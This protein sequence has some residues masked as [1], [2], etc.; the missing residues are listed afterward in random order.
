MRTDGLDP[1]SDSRSLRS[2]T[3]TVPF[4]SVAADP[5]FVY[6]SVPFIM[7]DEGVSFFEEGD[8]EVTKSYSD[9]HLLDPP[10][11]AVSLLSVLVWTSFAVPK[12]VKKSAA[13]S[14]SPFILKKLALSDGKVKLTVLLV[15]FSSAKAAFCFQTKFSLVCLPKVE[16]RFRSFASLTLRVGNFDDTSVFVVLFGCNNFACEVSS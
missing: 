6:A 13:S 2:D 3:N 10:G 1:P 15:S 16:R 8:L 4:S 9:H 12:R 14:R 7:M 11:F 5:G